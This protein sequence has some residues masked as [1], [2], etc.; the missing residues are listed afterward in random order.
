MTLED[1]IHQSQVDSMFRTSLRDQFT[2]VQTEQTEDNSR[3]G[4]KIEHRKKVT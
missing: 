4:D 2:I 3:N 1:N